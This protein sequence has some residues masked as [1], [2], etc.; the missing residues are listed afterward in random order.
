MVQ[1]ANAPVIEKYIKDQTEILKS[2][3]TPVSQVS[4]LVGVHF[5]WT[6]LPLSVC[7]PPPPLFVFP[8]IQV[9]NQNLVE[10]KPLVE[11]ASTPSAVQQA[12][13]D[14]FTLALIKP[15]AVQYYAEIKDII[16]RNLFQVTKE[17]QF[18]F[19]KE[20]AQVFYQEHATKPFFPNLVSYMS[21]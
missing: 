18:I 8:S 7:V 5:V 19:T 16:F 3:G 20:Q 4:R 11:V 13:P 2:G 1:G 12:R 14:D 21:R 10:L 9:E 15:D 17:K 6:A